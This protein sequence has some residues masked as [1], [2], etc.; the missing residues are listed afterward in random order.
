MTFAE[1]IGFLALCFALPTAWGL[2]VEWVFHVV[3]T[4]RAA[5][6]EA[7]ADGCGGPRP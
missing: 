3:R 7:S 2:L 6:A 4:R 1:K 5:K